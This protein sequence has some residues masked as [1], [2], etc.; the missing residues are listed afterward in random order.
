MPRHH[1][2]GS[3]PWPARWRRLPAQME[4]AVHIDDLAGRIPEAAAHQAG[5]CQRDVGGLPPAGDREILA[6]RDQPVVSVVH[7]PGHRGIDHPGPHL[8]HVD[9][10]GSQ[11]A[12]EQLGKHGQTGL[13]GAVFGP[14]D[15]HG[16]AVQ[17]TEVDDIAAR[18]VDD[19]LGDHLPGD[20][21]GQEEGGLQVGV[22]HEIPGILGD[23][24]QI[25]APLW[26]DPGIVDQHIEASEPGQRTGH[27]VL[28]V[29]GAVQIAGH[30][31]QS[32]GRSGRQFGKA[33]VGGEILFQ[34]RQVAALR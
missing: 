6:R 19:R 7:H 32:P 9:L 20:Q 12:G 13:G 4:A 16:I 22:Q 3:P 10:L 21:L 25:A 15:G 27:E 1:R 23:R 8:V 33:G 17:R 5:H 26:G 24:Q 30:R 31:P 18:R 14:I 34:Y 29:G 28:P 2:A 11:P